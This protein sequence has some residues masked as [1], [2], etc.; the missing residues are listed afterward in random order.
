MSVQ[1]LC[2]DTQPGVK[3]RIAVRSLRLRIKYVLPEL[4]SAIATKRI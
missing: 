3:Y 4:G 1:K 2:E